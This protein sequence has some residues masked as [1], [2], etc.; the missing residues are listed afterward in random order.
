MTNFERE[1]FPKMRVNKKK[2]H[3]IIDD[4]KADCKF[5]AACEGCEFNTPDFCKM[6]VIEHTLRKEP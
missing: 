4:I 3:K 5:M 1:I 6:H 2:L